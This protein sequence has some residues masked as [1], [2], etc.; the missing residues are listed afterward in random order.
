[1]PK[2]DLD[3]EVSKPDP[4]RGLDH[5]GATLTADADPALEPGQAT[6][7]RDAADLW[8]GE[9]IA[10]ADIT[11][12]SRADFIYHRLLAASDTVAIAL[13]VSISVALFAAIG[14]PLDVA[15]IGL[16]CAL[17]MSIW[18]ILAYG[19]GL[20]HEVER[21]IDY[22]YV[23]ELGMIV[24]VSTAWCWLFVLARSLVIDG[25]TELVVPALVWILMI[26]L[27]LFCRSFV[28]RHA[29]R[30]DWNRRQVATIGDRAGV[31]SLIQRIN[32]HPEWGLDVK[33]RV[34]VDSSQEFLV[35]EAE[36]GEESVSLIRSGAFPGDTQG[37]EQVNSKERAL[38]AV[39]EGAGVDRAIIAGEFQDLYSRTRLIHEL[40]ERGVAVDHISGGPE[41]LYSNAVFHDLE[42]LPVLSLRPTSPRPIAQRIKRLVDMCLSTFGLI[43][44]SPVFLWAAI[45]IKL[46]S[47]GP[48]FY[49]QT[50]CGLNGQ[51]FELYKFRTMVDGAHE[52][53]EDLRRETESTGNDD[54]LFK[55]DD[56]PRITKAGRTIR[57]LSIDEL[58]QLWNVLK[59]DMS[60]VGPRPLVFE[61]ALQATDLFS[62]RIRMKPGI[63]GPWQALGRSSI[64][65]EDMIKLDYAYVV[66]WSMSEDMKLLLRTL[67]AVTRRTGAV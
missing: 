40:V 56:D 48:V 58:P 43:V 36:G 11:S 29:R 4:A 17:M 61:E 13:S 50:R 18:F 44:S 65:F 20:Y 25:G 15:A 23:D 31:A 14:R 46:D 35:R 24:I 10:P 22:D 42:G 54:V 7:T 67:T 5:A 37:S 21:R 51:E 57:R 8:L 59:G 33:V 52:M 66:G 45:R 49:R 28:R 3:N 55:L 16:T 47:K 60:M 63:A 41:T 26:P 30:Q 6:G 9:S 53:R 38:A 34:E 12:G 19:A 62:A 32:R 1:M 39:I 27:L 64:P 2:S